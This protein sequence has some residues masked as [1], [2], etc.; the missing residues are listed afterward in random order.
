[1][2]H[3]PDGSTT[4]GDF[5]WVE[6]GLPVDQAKVSNPAVAIM[7]SSSR[8]RGGRLKVYPGRASARS[9]SGREQMQDQE[10]SSSHC[11]AAWSW[12]ASK[13][14]I[15]ARVNGLQTPAIHFSHF[16]SPTSAIFST[17]AQCWVENLMSSHSACRSQPWK[18]WHWARKR[19]LP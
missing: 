13:Y 10:L 5:I 12:E 3:H 9:F 16:V 6:L 17:S 8:Q 18:L 19:I 4:K 2:E 11:H 15:F 14:L 1:M 7:P